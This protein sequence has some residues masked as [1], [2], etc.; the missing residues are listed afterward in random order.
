MVLLGPL[1]YFGG[2]WG[3]LWGTLR[4]LKGTFGYLGALSF[5]LLLWG[6]CRYFWV[7]LG[8]FERICV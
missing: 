2:T 6:N 1:G 5:S 8:T 7:L 4:V 3:L